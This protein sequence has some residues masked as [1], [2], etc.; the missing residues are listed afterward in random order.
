MA[1][2]GR[3]TRSKIMDAAE[4]LILKQGFSATSVDSVI[5]AAGITK[6]TFFYHFDSKAALAKALVDRFAALDL[7]LL[8]DTM[9][10]A[11]SLSRDPLQQLLIFV[12]LFIEDAE[13]LTEPYPGCLF[14]SII[15]EGG[16]FDEDTL[17][18]ITTAYAA[19][20]K[21]LGDKLRQI[22]E[23]HPPREEVDLDSLAEMITVV[24][25]GAFIVSKTR[26]EPKV[27]AAQLGHYR[28]YL[29]LLFAG[30]RR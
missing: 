14:A 28:R 3:A 2:S 27:V 30:E 16:L 19:W 9:Q 11:E 8:E 26:R 12:G 15:Y 18:V 22:A 17:A 24:F 25:E 21:R 1:G 20:E 7:A 29:E 13:C 6:G 23:L 10:R 4:A 5:A